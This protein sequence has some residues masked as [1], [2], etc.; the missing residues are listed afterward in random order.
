MYKRLSQCLLA[1]LVL[2]AGPT[3]ADEEEELLELRNTVVNLLQALVARDVISAEEASAM[4]ADAQAAAREQSSAE[5]ELRDDDV[6]VTYVPD[7]V[8]D[9]IAEEVREEIRDAVVADVK[10]EAREEGWGIPAALPDWLRDVRV[11]GDVR[12]RFQG[13]YFASDNAL[14]TYLNFD[15]INRFGG[16]TLA[17]QN[18]IFNTS[19]DRNRLVGRVR[20]GASA[21]LSPSFSTGLRLSTGNLN[22]ATSPN[23]NYGRFS[24]RWDLGVDR[25]YFNWRPGDLGPFNQEFYFGRIGNPWSKS[26]LIWDE[27][28]AIEGVYYGIRS[29]EWGEGSGI[30]AGLGYFPTREIEISTDDGYQATAA[31]GGG[32]QLGEGGWFGLNA[33]YHQYGNIVGIRNTPD[34]QLNDLS[35]PP[36]LQR[37]NT[38]FDIRNDIDPATNLFA[39]ASEFELLNVTGMLR[40]RFPTGQ[41]LSFTADYVRN[42]GYDEADVL[43]RTGLAVEEQ[44]EGYKAALRLGTVDSGIPGNWA[45]ELS[46]RYLERDAVI[47]AFVDS[48]FGAGGTD[49]EGYVLAL[50]Y[51][52]IEDFTVR[53]RWMSST[54]IDG[55]PLSVDT[56]Q[57]D[58]VSRF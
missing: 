32:L 54:E 6:R 3:L 48:D 58:F 10:S 50:Y 45:V 47:D 4:V 1:L 14:N 29:A 44:S 31:L 33:A 13:D 55:P 41:E 22:D 43:A 46:Y 27:D 16:I 35:A 23:F 30:Q 5:P 39:L 7:I 20:F 25:A 19:E 40:A 21:N 28:V 8:R 15:Q 11:S 51:T 34:S 36:F 38:L 2:Q 37:G 12:V 56:L 57:I 49:T 52:F 17:G 9:Q 53:S 18:A 24:S 26:D 42:L